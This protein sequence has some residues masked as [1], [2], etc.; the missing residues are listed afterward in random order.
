MRTLWPAVAEAAAAWRG[1]VI[2]DLGR[3]QP[4]SPAVAVARQ[5]TAV[6]VLAQVS[7][8]GLF[9]L[10]ERVNELAHALGDPSRQRNPVAV[11]VSARRKDASAAVRQATHM[12]QAGGSPI[13]VAG[14]AAL[15]PSAAEQLRDGRMSKRVSGGD[16]L[17]GAGELAATLC[18]WWP[19]LSMGDEPAPPQP[20][21]VP[22]AM[23]DGGFGAPAAAAGWPRVPR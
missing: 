12:L 4:G 23:S 2:A 14:V 1:T 3:L 8:E 7:V 21:Q 5:A 11:V 9:H 19:Q 10:R 6:L 17:A 18:G 13:P 15:D 16:L 22:A 20:P